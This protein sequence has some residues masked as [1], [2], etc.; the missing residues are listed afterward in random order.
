[1][2]SKASHRT[3][4]IVTLK[5]AGYSRATIATKTEGSVSTVQYSALLK[6]TLRPRVQPQKK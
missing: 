2:T 3:A 6:G 4:E 1:M 5:A